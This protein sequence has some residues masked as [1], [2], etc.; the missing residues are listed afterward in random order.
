MLQVWMKIRVLATSS[1]CSM[2]VPETWRAVCRL[3]TPLQMQSQFREAAMEE[4]SY[5]SSDGGDG[6]SISNTVMFR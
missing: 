2:V 6:S 5:R 1:S 4:S 3:A